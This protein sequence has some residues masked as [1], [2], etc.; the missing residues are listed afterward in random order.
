M[1][2]GVAYRALR[3][4][5]K[6]RSQVKFK[7]FACSVLLSLLFLPFSA[8]AQTN[9]GG[10]EQTPIPKQQKPKDPKTVNIEFGVGAVSGRSKIDQM[11][12][13]QIG[14]IFSLG[15]VVKSKNSYM[16]GSLDYGPD[17]L[18]GLA[19]KFNSRFYQGKI[20]KK[21][22]IGSAVDFFHS[23]EHEPMLREPG[24]SADSLSKKYYLTLG[25]GALYGNI[26]DRYLQASYSIGGAYVRQDASFAYKDPDLNFTHSYNKDRQPVDSLRLGWMANNIWKFDLAGSIERTRTIHFFRENTKQLVIPP[27]YLLV[28][29]SAGITVNRHIKLSLDTTISNRPNGPVFLG[30]SLVARFI[31]K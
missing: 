16:R 14:R 19:L 8:N 23:R 9:K 27:N 31:L 6:K 28:E 26:D 18:G 4:P 24:V 5:L 12:P 13:F 2:K 17:K 21:L 1:L 7:L 15:S 3:S 25:I 20:S 11:L 29:A 10:A 22:S 30:N